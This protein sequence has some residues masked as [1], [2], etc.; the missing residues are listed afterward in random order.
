MPQIATQREDI[1][2]LA[3]VHLYH[4]GTSNCSQRV[5]LALQEKGVSWI[6]HPIN[7]LKNEHT[8]KEF[9]ALNPNGVVPVLVHDGSTIIESND[10]ISY[11]DDVFDGPR[12]MPVDR[13]HNAYVRQAI[14]NA[15]N[16]QTALKLVSHEFLFKPKRRMNPRQLAEYEAS[17]T[18][19]ALV[20]FIREF[21]TGKGFSEGKIRNSVAELTSAFTQLDSRLQSNAWLSGDDYG[22]ADISWIVN[23]HRLASMRYPFS[24]YPALANW[25]ARMRDRPSF[26]KAISNFESRR[27]VIAFAVYSR[28]RG[29]AG[30]GINHYL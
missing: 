3:G 30:S 23:V 26:D 17:C 29:W 9:Q 27:T 15:S 18:N 8:T 16:I 24:R 1:R 20:S 10:I 11:I 4:F 22:L 14:D 13:A 25:L 19:P 28:L 5:R 2:S 6:S 12:L 21:S 7:L